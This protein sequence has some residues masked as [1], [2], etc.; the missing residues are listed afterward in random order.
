LE[1]LYGKATFVN[2]AT[3]Q[4]ILFVGA[5]PRPAALE[6]F[7]SGDLAGRLQSRGWK[8]QVTSRQPGRLARLATIVLETWR[9]SARCDIACV[10]V[11]SGPAFLWAEAA[12]AILRRA[13]KPY[14]LT[15]HGGNLPDFSKRNPFRVKKLLNSAAAV[16]CPSPYLV[17]EMRQ[18]R[19]D[20]TL[21][22]NGVDLSRYRFRERQPPLRHLV[23]LR[24]FHAIY[25]PVMAVEVLAELRREHEMKLTMIGPDKGDG[26]L[27]QVK[28]EVRRLNLEGRVR[29]PGAVPKAAVPN[30]LNSGD[31]FLNTS[32]FDNTP[33]SVIEAM[34]C[35]LPVVTTNVGGIPYLLEHGKTALLVQP[36]NV[37]EMAAAVTRLVTKPD[38]AAQLSANGRKLAESF[39]WYVVLPQWLKLFTQLIPDRIT[40]TTEKPG[41]AESNIA[42][43]NE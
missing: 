37:A 18:F 13:R 35:G 11:F 12:C 6:R 40:R 43:K 3:P 21:I 14:V 33:V 16:T 24:A 9:G 4:S 8:V 23:W 22:P 1:R 32:H 2:A 17:T 20:L 39:D 36:G 30:A 15:L 27:E 42:G 41:F 25:N 19:P 29:L 10:D 5:F 31:I 38:L 26:S 7:V 28:S 34:A